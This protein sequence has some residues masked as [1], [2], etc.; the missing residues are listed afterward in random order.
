M[1]VI[2]Q[3]LEM[4]GDV[5]VFLRTNTD[6]A[7]ATRMKLLV[8]FDD[9]QKKACLRVEV[10]ATVDGG[11]PFVKATY[12]LEGDGPLALQCYEIMETVSAAV[13]LAHY[14]N[15]DAVSSDIAAGNLQIQQR[16]IAHAKMCIQPGIDYYTSH[17]AGCLH[18]SMMAFKAARLFSPQKV[19]HMQPSTIEVDTLSAFPFI[20]ANL[21]ADLKLSYHTT[22]QKLLMSVRIVILWSGG[23]EM[24]LLFHSGLQLQRRYCLFSLLLQQQSGC[25]RFLRHL[26]VI[27]SNRHFRTTLKP[28]FM[29]Q[30]NKN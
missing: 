10:A 17:L 23:K 2:K 16:M 28:H 29:L 30:Y 9:V 27:S 11:L 25:F 21:L 22:W 18:N 14:P 12:N 20:N 7:P 6:L 19:H 5:E 3:V 13:R 4:Y 24:N 8:I 15:V 26:L 1:E